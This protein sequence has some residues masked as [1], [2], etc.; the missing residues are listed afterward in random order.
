MQLLHALPKLLVA[1]LVVLLPLINSATTVSPNPL[2]IWFSDVKQ[3]QNAVSTAEL[4]L[5]TRT[6]QCTGPRVVLPA[7]D[8]S[9]L[10]LSHPSGLHPEYRQVV[11]PQRARRRLGLARCRL[12]VGYACPCCR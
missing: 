3:D 2:V 7:G 10:Y 6:H 11:Q 4:H 1:V 8:P 12:A 5:N 9:T